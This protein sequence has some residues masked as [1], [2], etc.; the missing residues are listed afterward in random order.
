MKLLMFISVLV[1]LI[2]IGVV[3]GAVLAG[4]GRGDR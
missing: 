2:C 4:R 1:V 3:I